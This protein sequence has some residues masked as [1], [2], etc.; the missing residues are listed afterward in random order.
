VEV[1]ITGGAGWIGSTIAWA[2]RDAGIEPTILDN[3][4]TGRRELAAAF[5]LYIGDI[6]DRAMLE[7]ILHEHPAIEAIVHCAASTIVPESTEHPLDYWANNVAGTVNLLRNATQ[8]GLRRVLFSSTAAI[9]APAPDGSVNEDSELAPSS[10]YARNKAA[11]EQVLVDAA[12][13][14]ELKALSLRY[15]NPVGA[16]PQLRTGQSIA[17]PSHV[18]GRIL[19]AHRSG[20]RFTITG[21][22]WP[23]RD[24]TGLRD[25]VHVWDLAL[26]HVAALQRFDEVVAPHGHQVMNL[27]SGT[28]TTVRELVTAVT[29]VAGP[30]DVVDGPARPGD[31]AGAW[32][33]CDR[34]TALLGWT[35]TLN[36]RQGV[37]DALRW[38][39]RRAEILGG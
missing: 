11:V 30:F 32:A 12:A 17:E 39:A 19:S 37:S 34:A 8:L 24:G 26:A 15:F 2:C 3:L 36:L 25:Y 20:T 23:T 29:E 31:V 6:A 35:P 16:D 33:R 22:D 10:P 18:L 1:L 7:Q 9:Y 27:G 13:A 5:P 14:G 38:D 21:T 28:G 4:R